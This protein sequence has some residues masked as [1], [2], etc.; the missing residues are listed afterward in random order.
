VTGELALSVRRGIRIEGLESYVPFMLPS[1]AQQLT[2]LV[3]DGPGR[4]RDCTDEAIWTSSNSDVAWLK[5]HDT[6]YVMAGQSGEAVVS[7]SCE[8]TTGSVVVRVDRYE[9]VVQLTDA[10]S[11]APVPDASVS[12]FY[13]RVTDAAGR[14]VA[15]GYQPSHT[16][17]FWKL[18]YDPATH[19]VSWN[20]TSR[21]SESY[22]LAPV[23][24]IFEQ[25][26]AR[27]C[28]TPQRACS[29]ADIANVGVHGFT[30]PRPGTLRVD[31]IWLPGGINDRLSY[32]LL[33]NGALVRSAT[34]FGSLRGRWSEVAAS[35]DCAYEFRVSQNYSGSTSYSYAFSVR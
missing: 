15:Q 20:R 21:V 33:C 10:E 34:A 9:I 5:T 19:T 1:D 7:A 28:G 14:V 8:G 30:V 25:G 27:I 4:T 24:G 16:L 13:G 26:S 32:E 18:G 22:A 12:P 3:V 2:A 17:S 11:G 23:P 35:T 31:T 6:G 29:A